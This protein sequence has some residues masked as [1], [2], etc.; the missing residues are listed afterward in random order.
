MIAVNETCGL[1]LLPMVLTTYV[2]QG[3]VYIA[4]FIASI[5]S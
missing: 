2:T 5:P 4:F 1:D 3:S